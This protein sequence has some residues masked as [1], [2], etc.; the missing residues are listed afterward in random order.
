[1]PS[2]YFR[3][4]GDIN[5]GTATNWSLSSGGPG[6]GDVPTFFDDAILDSNSGDCD[7]NSSNRTCK[8]FNCNG[9][10]GTLSGA[11]NLTVSGDVTLSSAMT[12]TMTGTLVENAVA[13]HLVSNGKRWPSNLTFNAF[14]LGTVTYFIDDNWVV[15]GNLTVGVSATLNHLSGNSISVGGNYSILTTNVVDGDTIIRMIGEGFISA[16]TQNNHGL[17]FEI[18]SS[19]ITTFGTNMGFGNFTYISGIT[20]TSG[21]T[22]IFGVRT[23][24]IKSSGVTWNDVIFSNANNF[25]IDLLDDMYI[26]GNLQWGTSN[27]NIYVVN[28]NNIYLY[29]NLVVPVRNNSAGTS[30]S[31]RIKFIGT[32]DQYWTCNGGD[33]LV[34]NNIDIEK[35]SGNLV[36]TGTVYYSQGTFTYLSGAVVTSGSVLVV[37]SSTLTKFQTS[38]MT[39]DNF[40]M[41]GNSTAVTLLSNM[42]LSGD[43]VV[44]GVTASIFLSGATLNVGRNVTINNS[45]LN[46]GLQGTTNIVMTGTGIWSGTGRLTNNLSFNTTGNINIAGPTVSFAGG[47][48]KYVSGTVTVEPSCV[49]HTNGGATYDV[50]AIRWRNVSWQQNTITFVGDF[51]CDSITISNT[52]VLNGGTIYC[53]GGFDGL[54]PSCLGTSKI[55]LKGSGTINGSLGFTR[56]RNNLEINTD[57]KLIVTNELSLEQ[58]T[59]VRGTIDATNCI[60]STFNFDI[61]RLQGFHKIF[62]PTINLQTNTTLIIDNFFRGQS[63]SKKTRIYSSGNKTN[64][65]ITGCTTSYAPFVHLDNIQVTKGCLIVPTINAHSGNTIGVIYNNNLHNGYP[66]DDNLLESKT[67]GRGGF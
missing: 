23:R 45:N 62:F 41:Q 30:G 58:A 13:T 12:I 20:V 56:I 25:T 18:A 59:Y 67:F 55:V 5:W 4:T 47:T 38:G 2:Y 27:S 39:W 3:N 24:T 34:R 21:N 50:T 8:N 54:V 49:L 37:P 16:R 33:G 42:N 36:L 10:T 46:D 6:D 14:S 64:V 66:S 32:S 26:S 40:V 61:M 11:F 15:G 35:P 53:H 48:L 57:G 9:Y 51:Y 29:G 17:S 52:Q 7:I 44:S 19:G 43:Y 28:N 22:S 60:L 63:D 1:M 31:T 65:Q